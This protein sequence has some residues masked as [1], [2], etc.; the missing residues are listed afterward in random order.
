LVQLPEGRS[1]IRE[2]VDHLGIRRQQ[3][4]VFV[5]RSEILA[6]RRMARL[7]K[8]DQFLGCL[9][10]DFC[11]GFAIGVS[12]NRNGGAGGSE[13]DNGGQPEG[14]FPNEI[15][16]YSPIPAFDFPQMVRQ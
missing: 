15:E 5:N 6:Q 1:E 2:G 10:S 12:A 8:G 3:F 9:V 7:A 13:D 14:D 16:Q 4:Q 11:R